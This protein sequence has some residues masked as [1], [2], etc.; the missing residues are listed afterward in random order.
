MAIL[1]KDLAQIQELNQEANQ[2]V[3]QTVLAVSGWLGNQSWAS[4]LPDASR[5]EFVREVLSLSLEGAELEQFAHILQDW[6][7]T[8]E[9]YSDPDA[10]AGLLEP[11]DDEEPIPLPRRKDTAGPSWR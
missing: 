10:I 8:A 1:E 11:A 3:E 2:A 9:A 4:H 7:A 6:Q 5:L